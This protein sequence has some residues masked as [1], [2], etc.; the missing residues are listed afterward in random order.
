MTSLQ[1]L[2]AGRTLQTLL[3]EKSQLLVRGFNLYPSPTH[4]NV[5]SATGAELNAKTAA[6]DQQHS[7]SEFSLLNCVWEALTTT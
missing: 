1:S 7:S 6:W 5:R 4:R 3:R 2:K